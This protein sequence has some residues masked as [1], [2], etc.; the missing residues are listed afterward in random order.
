MAKKLSKETVVCCFSA[1]KVDMKYTVKLFDQKTSVNFKKSIVDVYKSVYSLPPYEEDDNQIDSFSTSWESRSKKNGFTFIGA[2]DEAGQLVG[3]AYGWKS[4]VGDAWNTKLTA[5]L[6]N[7]SELW[8]SNCFEFVDLAVKPSAQGSGL[9][10]DLTKALFA[11]VNSK[12]AI[13]LTHQSTTKASE[14]YLRNGWVRLNE[15]FEVTPGK[16]YQIM[17]KFL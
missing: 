5:Q 17:G 16:Y 3:F 12:T 4:I 9:G 15:N 14:M 8:L 10:R 2:E 6:G 13:L 7:S 11:T 1:A